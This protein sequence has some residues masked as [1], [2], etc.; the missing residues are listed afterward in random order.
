ML[1]NVP[2]FETRL[3]QQMEI[4][5]SLR[6]VHTTLTSETKVF[7]KQ[8]QVLEMQMM[9]IFQP[10]GSRLPSPGGLSNNHFIDIELL[11]IT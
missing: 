4:Y 2:V 8:T 11:N 1:N 6:K 5:R 3:S 10:G 7:L 9:E